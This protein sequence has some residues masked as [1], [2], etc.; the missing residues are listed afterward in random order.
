M[1]WRHFLLLAV[2]GLVVMVFVSAFEPAPGYMDADAYYAGGRQ[3]ATGLGF[4]EP[5]L[6][7]YLDNPV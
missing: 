7:N 5:Y 2:L 4:T 3:L 1:T 6:W